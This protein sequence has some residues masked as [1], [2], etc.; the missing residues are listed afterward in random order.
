MTFFKFSVFTSK[1]LQAQMA[2]GWTMQHLLRDTAQLGSRKKN[3][4]KKEKPHSEPQWTIKGTHTCV[5]TNLTHNQSLIQLFNLCQI[6]NQ[7]LSLQYTMGIN[8]FLKCLIVQSRIQN[9]KG[10]IHKF[11]HIQPALAAVIKKYLVSCLWGCFPLLL[12]CN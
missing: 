8:G 1:G 6:L 2:T 5:F 11:L 9:L 3:Y 4:C 7:G 10:A 12:S